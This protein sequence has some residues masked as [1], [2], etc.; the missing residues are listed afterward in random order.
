LIDSYYKEFIYCI[1]TESKYIHVDDIV[2]FDWDEITD[3]EVTRRLVNIKD[4][5]INDI[6]KFG[7]NILG[8]VKI[9]AK[10]INNVQEYNINNNYITG[11]NNLVFK[12][13][14]LGRYNSTINMTGYQKI[15]PKYLYHL[16]TDTKTFKINNITFF[17]YSFSLEHC[18]INDTYVSSILTY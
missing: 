12:D 3:E 5:E 16:I 6:L 2:F 15:R 1:N 11:S 17:D 13:E 4:I 7:E 10:N 8:V 14:T 18:L 9:D